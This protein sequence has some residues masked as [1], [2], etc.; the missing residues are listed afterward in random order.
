MFRNF[1]VDFHTRT[2]PKTRTEKKCFEVEISSFSDLAIEIAR[3][4]WTLTKIERFH[5][6]HEGETISMVRNRDI[7]QVIS[8]IFIFSWL[9]YIFWFWLLDLAIVVTIFN[10]FILLCFALKIS[11]RYRELGETE[12]STRLFFFVYIYYVYVFLKVN[13]F[14]F[15]FLSKQFP[16][17]FL[18]VILFLVL[19]VSRAFHSQ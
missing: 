14:W 2:R 10:S 1:I 6:Q 3:L 19:F 17:R 11:E 12:P 4:K 7:S 13:W 5:V 18:L 8:N 15:I 16:V 9:N